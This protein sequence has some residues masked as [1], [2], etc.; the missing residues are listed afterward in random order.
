MLQ[1]YKTISK[2]M[3]FQPWIKIN[4]GFGNLLLMAQLYEVG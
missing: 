3:T 4:Y 1:D 2:P